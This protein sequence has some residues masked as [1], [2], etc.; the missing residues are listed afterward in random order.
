MHRLGHDLIRLLGWVPSCILPVVVARA[1]PAARRA[2][3]ISR[4]RTS[5]LRNLSSLQSGDFLRLSGARVSAEKVVVIGQGYVGLPLAMRAVEA[6]F[7]VVGLDVDADRVKRLASGESFVEDIPADRLG[8]ALGSGRY[9]PSTEYADARGFDVCVITVPTPLRDGTPDLSYVEQA[10]RGIGPYVRPGSTVV[11]ESTTYPGTTEELLRPLLESASGLHAP[12]D[13]HLGYSPERIDPGNPTWRLENTPKVVAGVDEPSLER[14]DGFYRRIVERTV[15]V[16][17]TRVAE[18]TKLIENT[19]RQVNLGLINELTVLSHHLGIDVW[20]AIDA[21]ETKPFGFMPFRP[22]PGV[23]GHCLPIDPCYL[24]WQV[25]RRL[26]RQFRF[27]ELANDVNHEMPE[28]VAQRVM[29]GLNRTGRAVNG[30]RLLMLGL[31]YKKNT[32]DMRDSP[33]VDVARRLCDLGA[34]V[35]AAE[36]YAEAHQ[37]PGGVLVVPLTEQEVDA[38][39]AVV[40]TTDHDVFDYEMVSRRAR[41]VFDARNRC[42]G[43]VVERL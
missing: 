2:G 43:P 3:P 23:G 11:L 36:P 33:A 22:G 15:P 24:S 14:V 8:R 37:I 39:D 19:F 18:L 16:S 31:A 1:A 20:Q 12:G 28:H 30:A 41:Y 38:A 35:R 5:G 17:S 21:A 13:F 40:V 10:G 6:G 26:G 42:S 32:G 29:A 27:I 4:K 9:L 25:K 34:D 7:D